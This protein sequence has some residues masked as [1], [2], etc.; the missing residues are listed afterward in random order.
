MRSDMLVKFLATFFRLNRRP[1]EGLA[2]F[3]HLTETPYARA[4]VRARV[5]LLPSGA[6]R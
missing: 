6:D 1:P 5:N 3:D 4:R 2:E